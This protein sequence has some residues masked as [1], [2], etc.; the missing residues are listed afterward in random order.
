MP[1]V[2]LNLIDDAWSAFSKATKVTDRDSYRPFL[3][4]LGYANPVN[5]PFKRFKREYCVEESVADRL[6]MITGPHGYALI[7]AW[8]AQN[9]TSIEAIS[10]F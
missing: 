6:H 1:L 8:Q 5:D 9:E 4:F 10:N 2:N 3:H 7:K